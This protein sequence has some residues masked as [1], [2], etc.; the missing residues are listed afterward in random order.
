MLAP[1]VRRGSAWECVHGSMFMSVCVG[2]GEGGW[3]IVLRQTAVKI[4]G[5]GEKGRQCDII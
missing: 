1:G 4:K 3:K 2:G 5:Q